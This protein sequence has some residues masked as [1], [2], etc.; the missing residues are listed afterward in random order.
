M[1][2][3]RY[4]Y[5]SD[6]ERSGVDFSPFATCD[7]TR[8]T[9][10]DMCYRY[11]GQYNGLF[12]IFCR[13]FQLKFFEDTRGLRLFLFRDTDSSPARIQSLPYTPLLHFQ[14]NRP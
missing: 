11:S 3:T 10:L 13:E 5:V 6:L 12:S 1:C 2:Y 14:I 8:A 9:I 7:T 4:N